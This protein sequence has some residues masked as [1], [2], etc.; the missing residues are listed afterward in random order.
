MEFS[1]LPRSH[2]S[3][4]TKPL[5]APK[6]FRFRPKGVALLAVAF[7]VFNQSIYKLQNIALGLDVGQRVIVHTFRKIHAVEYLD[8]VALLLQ[9]MADLT[10]YA[11]LWVYAHITAMGLEQLRG[12]PKPCFS[13]TARTDDTGVKVSGV[14]GIVG[15]GVHGE[16]FCACQ[17]HVVLK[18]RVDKR[19]Y[20]FFCSP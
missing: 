6:R 4:T 12:Q 14:G 17:Y 16:K 8:F 10:E 11:A 2:T 3:G 1:L 19:L 7:R 5:R 18:F 15:P 13:A 20:V 9:K